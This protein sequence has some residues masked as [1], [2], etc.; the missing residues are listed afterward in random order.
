[1]GKVWE[2]KS[3]DED[4]FEVD[5]SGNRIS[6]SKD[7]A[8]NAAYAGATGTQNPYTNEAGSSI[9]DASGLIPGNEPGSTLPKGP[10]PGGW[11]DQG[12]IQQYLRN[13]TMPALPTAPRATGGAA[14]GS[15]APTGGTAPPYQ[16]LN[17]RSANRAS[18]DPGG[19]TPPTDPAVY[20]DMDRAR[21]GLAN[22]Y[23]QFLGR[24]A[25]EGEI[26]SWLSGAYGHGSGVKDYDRYV[27]AIMGSD[28]A[29]RHDPNGSAPAAPGGY[30]SIEWWQQQGTPTIDIFDPMTGQL[31]PGWTRTA[32]GYERTGAPAGPAAGS[33][34]GPQGGNFQSWFASLT[35]GKRPSPKTLK[36]LEPV[37]AQY[38]IRLGPLNARGFTDGI[39]LPNGQFVDVIMS[40][41]EDGGSGWGWI[42]PDGTGHGSSSGAAG[43]WTGG[44]NTFNDQWTAQLESLLQSRIGSLGPVN[45]PN[46]ARYEQ[47][48]RDRATQLSAAEPAYQQLLS[49]LQQRFTDLQGPGYTGAENEVIR[50]GALDPLEA[51][52]A[53]AKK[54]VTE[55]L[56][57]RGLTP[58]S[59][60]YQAALLDVD[61]A[62]DAM[63][64]TT[65]TALTT[66]DLNR[67]EDRA[68]RAS[69]IGAQLVD[70]PEGRKREQLD[71]FSALE[72][73]SSAARQENDARAREAIGYGG[74]LAD[75]A[76]Q[77]MQ[78][79]MQAAG[80]GGSPNDMFSSLM[81][82]A[83]LNQNSALFANQNRNSMWSGLGS[84]LAVLSNAGR[85]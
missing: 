31:K 66:N 51:D 41:T 14:T 43:G 9:Y 76:P 84:I 22:V 78:L 32:K 81:Q 4:W 58:D 57:A 74:A 53:A 45:D 28:E 61:K 44:P 50:T 29:R 10:A 56:A 26:N 5:G 82:M 18:G 73:L 20:T 54:R 48:L 42:I 39:I 65:Q 60:I 72:L 68:Q 36:E 8:A 37:L 17:T 13:L 38:G 59:G 64:G 47:A 75:L 24:D 77:R 2:G 63:R 6:D 27:S 67:R 34:G 62:F 11:V 16:G 46:R 70:I 19:G 21:Q 80:M 1:M 49:F 52:R 69:T 55:R 25:S 83:G 3:Y 12:R 71:V 15:P 35:N 40:A 30:Q 33:T 23:R 7:W 85:R 79:A